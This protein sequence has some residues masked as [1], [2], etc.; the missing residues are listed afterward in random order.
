ML[1]SIRQFINSRKNLENYIDRANI[2]NR[3]DC[4]DGAGTGWIKSISD[5][6]YRDYKKFLNSHEV[7]HFMDLIGDPLSIYS[8]SR[9]IREDKLPTYSF[10]RKHLCPIVHLIRRYV[11]PIDNELNDI[12]RKVINDNTYE[13][14]L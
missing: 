4:Y 8:I 6:K 1:K 12:I 3:P 14:R 2:A 13:F 9:R 10:Q 5:K 11:L 7:T